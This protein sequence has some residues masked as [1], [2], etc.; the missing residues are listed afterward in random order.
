MSKMGEEKE[1]NERR[2]EVKIKENNNEL[3]IL[4]TSLYTLAAFE[5]TLLRVNK[6]FELK[7]NPKI[8]LARFQFLRQEIQRYSE[9]VRRNLYLIVEAVKSFFPEPSEEFYSNLARYLKQ[10]RLPYEIVLKY[11][12]LLP[13]SPQFQITLMNPKL[14][15]KRSD[16]FIS[17][18]EQRVYQPASESAEQLIKAMLETIK[19]NNKK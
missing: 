16:I 13:G 9:I 15:R 10:K 7:N 4:V 6:V 5:E 12:V 11:A 18:R 19:G 14:S 2:H 3:A 1:K 8:D 17:R